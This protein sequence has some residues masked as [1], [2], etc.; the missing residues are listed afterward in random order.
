MSI[1][2]RTCKGEVLASFATVSAK[3]RLL[4]HAVELKLIYMQKFNHAASNWSETSFFTIGRDKF[5]KLA[6]IVG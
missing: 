5:L 1:H 3:T 6:N 4:D 2:A